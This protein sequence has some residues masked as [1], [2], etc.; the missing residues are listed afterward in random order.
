MSFSHLTDLALSS[1]GVLFVMPILLLVTLTVSFERVWYLARLMST[2]RATIARVADL[3]N[4]DQG[5]LERELVHVDGQPIGS[6]L[7]VPLAFPD[8]RD[9]ARL[10]DRLE[11]AILREVPRVDRS[12]WLLDTAVTLAPLLGLL[13]TI[14]GMFNAFQVLGQPGTAPTEITGGVAEALIAT[15]SGLFIAIIGLVFFNSLQA[16]VRLV[17]HDLETLKMILVN[18]LSGDAEAEV[19]VTRSVSVRGI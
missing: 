17:V 4:L 19:Q 12:L 9:H 6:V 11:E 13:G 14:I 1:G 7:R 5:E 10:A 15:A 8:E 16:R 2:S 18:R 3:T